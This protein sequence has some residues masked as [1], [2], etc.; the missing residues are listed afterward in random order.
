MGLGRPMGKKK[1]IK[2]EEVIDALQAMNGNISLAA[3][4]LKTTRQNIEYYI[5]H[6]ATVQAAFEQTTEQISDIA[7]G[8]LVKA[9]KAGKMAEVRYW[10]DNK[11]RDRGFGK[12]PAVN[13]LDA[14][15][16][17]QILALS[18]EELDAYIDKYTRLSNRRA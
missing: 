5:K 14:F 8:H 3:R 11:A 9:V 18:D 2:A 1:G 12:A 6:Y 16:P 7:L 10:L 17:E 13:P 15:T 4:L